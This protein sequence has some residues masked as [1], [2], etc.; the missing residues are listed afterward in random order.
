M[1]IAFFYAKNFEKPQFDAV[2]DNHGHDIR[3]I[4]AALNST[5]APLANGCDAVCIFVNDKCDAATVDILAAGG[6]RLILC[7]SAG[8]N[9][10][11][12]A[13]VKRHGMTV[14]RVPA[15]SPES[16]AE[17]AVGMILTL[18]RN[19][20]HQYNR[21][22][23]GNFAM[24]NLVG[25]TLAG[26]TAGIV[27]TGNIG[28]ATARILKGFGCKLL[29]SDPYPHADMTAL[30]MTYVERDELFR[31][32]DVVVLT[33]PLTPETRY[34]INS[35]SL[36]LFKRGS[37]LINTGR[38]PLIETKAVIAALK[39][40]ETIHYLGIDVYEDEAGLFFENLSTEIVQDDTLQLLT[41]FKNCLITP[42]SAWLTREALNDIAAIT[43]G[44][45]TDFLA[46]KPDPDRTVKLP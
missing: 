5:T 14:M 19:L 23:N 44:N 46:G 11:D 17:H 30:G 18:V 45:A 38:G 1:K 35:D 20:H 42:H 12:L 7:R 6:V 34:M 4:D 13:A 2:N 39:N 3:Y 21:V 8:F 26:R 29:G 25:F 22:R 40:L 16:I 27:G 33:A 32:S 10:V 41:T 24:D 36:K 9:Q 37:V 43:L 28:R 15:Y 31:Q